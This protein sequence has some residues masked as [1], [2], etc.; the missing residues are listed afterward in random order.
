M[1][2]STHSSR[3][4]TLMNFPKKLPQNGTSTTTIDPSEPVDDDDDDD[5]QT[6]GSVIGATDCATGTQI[7]DNRGSVSNR[8]GAHM[9][10]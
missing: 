5:D 1:D 9:C 2:D 4:D 3:Y 6:D 7:T 10:V 8:G